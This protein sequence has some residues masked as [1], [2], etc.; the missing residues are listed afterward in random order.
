M[1]FDVN[2]ETFVRG[3]QGR[4]LG[5]GPGLQYAIHF[6]A[7]VVVQTSRVVTLDDKGIVTLAWRSATRF[8][9]VTLRPFPTVFAQRVHLTSIGEL[10]LIV[11][12]G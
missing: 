3:I 9:A 5:H 2:G 12:F 6:Q 8:R 11:Q 7:K 4:P 1:I 10:L